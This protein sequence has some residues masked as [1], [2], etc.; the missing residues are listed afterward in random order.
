MSNMK[1]REV[2]VKHTIRNDIILVVCLL[3][4][5][6]I[7]IFYLFVLRHR[8]DA[9]EV[10]VDGK[11]YGTYLL[12]KDITEDIHTGKNNECLNRLVIK[13]GKAYMQTATCPDGIC[14]AH[15]PIFRDGESIV[16]LPQ[17]VVITVV[18]HNNAD[19]PDIIA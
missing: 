17:R 16:C 12:S 3:L 1:E 4:V 5:A 7:G 13:E 8:G 6:A 9:V 11:P 14:V 18:M 19:G 10:K 15:A 2:S